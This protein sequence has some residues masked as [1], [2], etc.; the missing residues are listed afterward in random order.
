LQGDVRQF[1]QH[2]GQ[3]PGGWQAGVGVKTAGLDGEAAEPQH[4]RVLN[5]VLAQAAHWL[6]LFWKHFDGFGDVFGATAQR[7][8]V[9][10]AAIWVGGSQIAE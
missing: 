10:N 9:Q 8:Q 3:M 2:A 1:P 4:G 5:Q 6:R 7:L